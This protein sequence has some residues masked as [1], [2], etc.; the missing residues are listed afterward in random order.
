MHTNYLLNKLLERHV[1]G[2]LTA[3]LEEISMPVG[4]YKRQVNNRAINRNKLCLSNYTAFICMCLIGCIQLVDWTTG[5]D[6]WTALSPGTCEITAYTSNLSTTIQ[7]CTSSCM[8]FHLA[9]AKLLCTL[10]ICLPLEVH[11]ILHA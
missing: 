7:K 10:V 9:H 2:H 5:L 3:Y 1:E 11:I 4:I 6:Y 8:P